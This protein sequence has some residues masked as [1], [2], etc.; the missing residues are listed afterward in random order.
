MFLILGFSLN[1]DCKFSSLL[2]EEKLCNTFRNT[3]SA[4]GL[5][6]SCKKLV[7]RHLLHNILL[8]NLHLFRLII[9]VSQSSLDSIVSRTA[10]SARAIVTPLI[11]MHRLGKMHAFLLINQIFENGKELIKTLSAVVES[12]FNP[13]KSPILT[14]F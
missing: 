10:W 13:R 9:F 5:V 2:L 3:T 14:M 1:Y 11:N 7:F 8:F 12:H 4:C 6:H